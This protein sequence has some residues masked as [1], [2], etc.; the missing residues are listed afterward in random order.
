MKRQ[1]IKNHKVKV[2]VKPLDEMFKRQLVFQL[3]LGGFNVVA[4]GETMD[5]VTLTKIN[6]QLTAM[7]QETCEARDWLPWKSWSK[8]PKVMTKEERWE[9]LNELVDVQHFLINAALAVGCTS[10][11]FA[12]IF[13]NKQH[14]NAL[15]QKRGY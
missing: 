14:E 3:R 6:E 8:K 10:K 7:V 2:P 13:F 1:T 15:R 9:Y 12:Q 11:E 4:P 5:A